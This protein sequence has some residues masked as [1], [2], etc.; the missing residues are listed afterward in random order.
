MGYRKDKETKE[1]LTLRVLSDNAPDMK[2][3]AACHLAKDYGET[4]AKRI[5]YSAA[6]AILAETSLGFGPHGEIPHDDNRRSAICWA[7]QI[8]QDC[9]GGW[10]IGPIP[11]ESLMVEKDAEW[12]SLR[13]GD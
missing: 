9:H 13:R 5:Q 3:R 2:L 12:Q 7:L 8:A 4:F 10:S 6:L 1:L 11:F